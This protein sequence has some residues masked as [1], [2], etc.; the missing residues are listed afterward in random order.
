MGVDDSVVEVI[1]KVS[2]SVVNINTLRVF[3]DV[4]FLTVPVKGMGSGFILD[5]RGYILTNSHV[6]EETERIA[7]T[8]IDGDMLD[9]KLVGTCRSVDTAIIKI[10]GSNLV[11]AELGDSDKLKVGQ[12]VFAMGNTG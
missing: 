9:G 2:R 7:V 1:E 6:I 11:T 8:L 12:R 4:F 3:Q 10:E 5:E